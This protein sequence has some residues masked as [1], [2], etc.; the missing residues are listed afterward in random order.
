MEAV[1]NALVEPDPEPLFH[2]VFH[3]AVE[4]SRDLKYRFK[5]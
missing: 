4:K 2:R 5:D 1:A 3:K